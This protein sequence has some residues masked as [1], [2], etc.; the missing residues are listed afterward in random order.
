MESSTFGKVSD[1]MDGSEL[2]S[3]PHQQV[4]RRGRVAW[5]TQPPQGV[6]RV[7]VESH[8][9]GAIEV[10]VPEGDPIPDEA[11]PGELLAITHGICMASVLSQELAEGGSTANELV[12]E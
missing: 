1:S 3:H 4:V 8:A 2:Q 6:A 12:V 10:S 5:L 9:F 7:S 11:T